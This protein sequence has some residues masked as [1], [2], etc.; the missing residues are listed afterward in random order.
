MNITTSERSSIRQAICQ[1]MVYYYEDIE[2][3]ISAETQDHAF[4]GLAKFRPP[5]NNVSTLLLCGG[6]LT[7]E[8]AEETVLAQAKVLISKGNAVLNHRAGTAIE[9]ETL[10]AKLQRLWNSRTIQLGLAI[11]FIIDG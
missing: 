4:A 10:L 8:E 11:Q 2:I 9:R 5:V 7:P 1:V 3:E 6:F